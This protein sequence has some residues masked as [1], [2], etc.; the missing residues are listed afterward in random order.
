MQQLNGFRPGAPNQTRILLEIINKTRI[1]NLTKLNIMSLMT[2]PLLV[3]TLP[4]TNI[5]SAHCQWGLLR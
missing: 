3:N 1:E 2:S 5:E 4:S